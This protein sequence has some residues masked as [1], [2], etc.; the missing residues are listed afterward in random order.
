M[1]CTGDPAG[2]QWLVCD[3]VP[4]VRD[5]A[6]VGCRRR[7][8]R[9]RGGGRRAPSVRWV[10]QVLLVVPAL[11]GIVALPSAETPGQ[12]PD[13]DYTTGA[14][15][16]FRRGRH[17]RGR[18]GRIGDHSPSGTTRYRHGGRPAAVHHTRRRAGIRDDRPAAVR[19]GSGAPAP[20]HHR[21]GLAMW[22]IR[23]WSS[24]MAA[25]GR[26]SRPTV[27]RSGCVSMIAVVALAASMA[28]EPH[29][30]ARARVHRLDVFLGYAL[31]DPP[32]CRRS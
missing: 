29:R 27:T 4:G 22:V 15:I 11:I 18:H 3:A 19:T 1:R 7:R 2:G 30:S 20:R 24:R 32:S 12:G 14:A 21:V 5:V 31:P 16:V 17:I 8:G 23:R 9:R 25:A 13:H 26:C 6:C 28:T 10:T